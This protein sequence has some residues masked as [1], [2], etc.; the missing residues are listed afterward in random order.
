MNTK[1]QTYLTKIFNTTNYNHLFIHGPTGC[2]KKTLLYK[3]LGAKHLTEYN[4]EKLE[5]KKWDCNYFIHASNINK[6]KKHF[7]SIVK[8]ITET[9]IGGSLQHI[10]ILNSDNLHHQILYFL[11]RF[12]ETST[13]TTR[14]I[15]VS[16][17]C[18]GPISAIR[19][20]CMF[21]RVPYPPINEYRTFI[22]K[23]CKKHCV[24]FEEHYLSIQNISVS[25]DIIFLASIGAEYIDNVKKF[26]L[27]AK[28]NI[29]NNNEVSVE[30]HTIIKEGYSCQ[31]IIKQ[32]S[33][34]C[35]D[36]KS[37]QILAK[38][39]HLMCIGYRELIHMEALFYKLSLID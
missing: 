33:L 13:E 11:R 39:D 15:F 10:C 30:L 18:R 37:I 9:N 36:S 6:Y 29:K 35:N 7:I 31:D 2:G 22:M 25:I 38:Y 17:S 19:S 16:S 23:Y 34:L 28:E 21:I 14:F 27:F 3:S 24:K 12:L 1:V 8:D 32:Y 5:Y 20:R 26:C 4:Y